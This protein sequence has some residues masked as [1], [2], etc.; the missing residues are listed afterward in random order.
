MLNV[1]YSRRLKTTGVHAYHDKPMVTKSPKGKSGFPLFIGAI[2][3][4]TG[5][6]VVGLNLN[7]SEQKFQN[8]QSELSLNNVSSEKLAVENQEKVSDKAANVEE[9]NSHLG[10]N[11][12]NSANNDSSN[13]QI[14]SSASPAFYPKNL[15]FPPKMDQINYIIEIGGY[16]P[17]E[18]FRIGKMISSDMPELQGKLFR[19]S[20]GKLFAGY[21]YSQE[22]AKESLEHLRA[23]EKDDFTD[24][25]IKTVRF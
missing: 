7:Q 3:L 6:M 11:D 9:S 21:F 4:F 13:K 25:S 20:T 18:S 17:A 24:A 16:E 19:T 1:D 8:N 2:L 10:S 14:A 5:G 23:F 22:E 15:K 12:R